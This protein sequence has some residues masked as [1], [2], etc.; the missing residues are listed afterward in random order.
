MF[1]PEARA[2]HL[3][4][5][6]LRPWLAER[7]VNGRTYAGQLG[8][9]W[10]WPRRFAYGLAWPLI[11]AVR[12]ARLAPIASAAGVSAKAM[13]AF[14]LALILASA[15]EGVGFLFGPSEAPRHRRRLEIEK[16]HLVRPGEA[17]AALR[18]VVALDEPA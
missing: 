7:V 9:T 1:E 6:H 8:E 13:P 3:N 10:R 4:V 15:G 14:V 16:G 2:H 5:S 11:A 18:R 17:S 12:F